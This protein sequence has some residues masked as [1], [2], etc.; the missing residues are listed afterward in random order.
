MT[1]DKSGRRKSDNNNTLRSLSICKLMGTQ[2]EM[3]T[4]TRNIKRKKSKQ[5]W[6]KTTG[7]M[8]QKMATDTL[9][10]EQGQEGAETSVGNWRLHGRGTRGDWAFGE[11]GSNSQDTQCPWLQCPEFFQYYQP[12]FFKLKILLSRLKRDVLRS[13]VCDQNIFLKI[14]IWCYSDSSRVL[15]SA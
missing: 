11:S 1:E 3:P 9:L 5:L 7:Q 14:I 4:G 15:T 12:V 10:Q 8:L 6:E 2:T 13:M